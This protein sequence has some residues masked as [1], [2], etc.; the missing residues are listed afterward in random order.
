[1]M[2][3]ATARF[4]LPLIQVGQGQKELTHNEALHRLDRFMHLSVVSRSAAAPPISPPAGAIWIVPAGASGAWTGF[5]GKLA[6]WNG[7]A[8]RMTESQSG[9]LCWI[10]DEAILAVFGA[11]I[12]NADFLPVSG[13][14]IGSAEIF[15]APRAEVMEPAGGSVIDVQARAVI[16]LLLGYLRTQGIVGS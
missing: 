4:E 2:A 9:T 10:A 5:A 1:M 7:S 8:W 11:N 15:G 13:L 3:E 6:E 12:W 16:G 14:R